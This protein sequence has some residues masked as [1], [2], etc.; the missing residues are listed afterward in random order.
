[1][2]DH[3]SVYTS[4]SVRQ[5]RHIVSEWWNSPTIYTFLKHEARTR[6]SLHYIAYLE[7]GRFFVTSAKL[8]IPFLS[9]S[10]LPYNSEQALEGRLMLSKGWK[11]KI[12]SRK[13]IPF[14]P[15]S[16]HDIYARAHTHIH[17]WP[18]TKLVTKGDWPWWWGAQDS[19]WGI[20]SDVF[21]GYDK[22]IY[23]I[24]I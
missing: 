8:H 4:S 11:E 9:L 14:F 5:S 22:T 21:E 12:K 10:C 17:S 19:W 13:F 15:S 7:K 16:H 23:V 20:S 18:S 1:M 3:S 2:W 6:Y 24:F